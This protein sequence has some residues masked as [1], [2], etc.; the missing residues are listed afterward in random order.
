LVQIATAL[1]A[2]TLVTRKRWMLVGV[3]SAAGLGVVA[4]LIGYLHL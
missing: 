3:Y 2:I 4:G 1:S